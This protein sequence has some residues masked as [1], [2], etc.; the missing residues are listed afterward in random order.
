[1]PAATAS[2]YIL[3]AASVGL[4]GLATPRTRWPLWSTCWVKRMVIAMV[5]LVLSAQV[6]GAGVRLGVRDHDVGGVGV[7]DLRPDL[8]AGGVDHDDFGACGQPVGDRP[9]RGG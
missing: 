7:V 1:M 4:E 8:T 3:L 2:T 9:G 5:L 6:G